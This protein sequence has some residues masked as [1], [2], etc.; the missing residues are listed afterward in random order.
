MEEC[1]KKVY[2]KKTKKDIE[3]QYE[4]GKKTLKAYVDANK[5]TKFRLVKNIVGRFKKMLKQMTLKKRMK[6]GEEDYRQVFCNPDCKATLFE[7]GEPDKL[8]PDLIKA[9]KKELKDFHLDFNVT[10]W[11]E[12]RKQLFGKDKTVLKNGFYKGIK[13]KTVKTLRNRGAL[14][15]CYQ[16]NVA[17]LK[18]VGPLL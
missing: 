5:N 16:E 6:K 11:V 1:L 18:L 3:T 8:S 4:S 17:G 15:G 12:M 2:N 9:L 13:K 10:D 14:S 7:E